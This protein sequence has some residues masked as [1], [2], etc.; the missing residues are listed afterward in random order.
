MKVSGLPRGHKIEFSA[1]RDYLL[2]LI[3]RKASFDDSEVVVAG[4]CSDDYAGA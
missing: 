4:F 3:E 1:Q 2:Q